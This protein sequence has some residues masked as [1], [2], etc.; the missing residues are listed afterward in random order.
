[1]QRVVRAGRGATPALCVV[2]LLACAGCVASRA[3][4]LRQYQDAKTAATITVGAQ[5]LVFARERP[6]RAVHARDYLSLV[7]LDINRA[8][9]HR[10]LVLIYD[11]LTVEPA[12][13]AGSEPAERYSLVADGR[14]IDLEPDGSSPRDAGLSSEPVEPPAHHAK[15]AYVP[16]TREELAYLVAAGE[17]RA[18]RTVS[19]ERISYELWRDDRATIETFLAQVPASTE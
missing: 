16:M 5:M 11:W 3:T 9:T 12:P 8:G 19:G 1:M 13:G 4:T 14:E 17:L 2:A 7:P 15:A 10:L 18:V 6:E